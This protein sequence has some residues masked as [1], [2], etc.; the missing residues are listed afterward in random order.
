MNYLLGKKI[1]IVSLLLLSANIIFAQR[2]GG[3]KPSGNMPSMKAPKINIE[4][5]LGLKYYDIEEA[6]KRSKTKKKSEVKS[7]FFEFNRKI[8]MIKAFH[9]IEIN[10]AQDKID[11]QIS[12]AIAERN[13]DKVSEVMK[14]STRNL[15]PIKKKI[16][17]AN[18]DLDTDLEKIMREKSFKK[19][20]DYK[21]ST[22]QKK[23]MPN[24]P[25]QRPTGRQRM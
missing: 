14:N 13:R 19:W 16:T 3:R 7:A 22:K 24:M 11:S 17:E 12:Q 8:D 15:Q 10:I 20:K 18:N 23:K 25:Q 5:I 6:I 9:Q 2:P 1:F 4:K 21:K